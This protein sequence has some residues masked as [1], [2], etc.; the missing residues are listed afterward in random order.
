MNCIRKIIII[1][2]TSCDTSTPIQTVTGFMRNQVCVH[3][4]QC[5]L[6]GC[7]Y[8]DCTKLMISRSSLNVYF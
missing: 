2:Y 6:L 1:F 7:Y 3:V 8:V 5:I 4:Y